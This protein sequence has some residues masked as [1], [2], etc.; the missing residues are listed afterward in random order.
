MVV[1]FALSSFYTA[2]I[3]PAA[4][5][6][7]SLTFTGSSSLIRVTHPT[8]R[9]ASYLNVLTYG[10]SINVTG[11]DSLNSKQNL[12]LSYNLSKDLYT[13]TSVNGT[14]D[15]ITSFKQVSYV[16]VDS[17]ISSSYGMVSGTDNTGKP[18]SFPVGDIVSIG[19]NGRVL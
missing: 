12:K 10:D 13:L 11:L 4:L 9:G 1:G 3:A 8:K 19:T 7:N 14:I 18:Q 16:L 15:A 6:S 2:S 5:P 17:T